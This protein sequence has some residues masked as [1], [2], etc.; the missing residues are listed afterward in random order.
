M[1]VHPALVPLDHPLAG[2]RGAFNAVF[3]EAQAAGVPVLAYGRGG[4]RDTVV[5]GVSGLFFAEQTPESLADAILRFEARDWPDAPIRQNARR[6]GRQVFL[7]GL[8]RGV[9]R[10]GDARRAAI[11]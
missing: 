5:D 2:V 10:A 6:F 3:V 4:A 1:R 9:L 7:D 8:A 11:R